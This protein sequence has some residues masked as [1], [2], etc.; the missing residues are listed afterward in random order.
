MRDP[1]GYSTWSSV[2]IDHEK[3]EQVVN[4]VVRDLNLELSRMNVSAHGVILYE[5]DGHPED[6]CRLFLSPQLYSSLKPFR[7]KWGFRNSAPPL[8]LNPVPLVETRELAAV[9]EY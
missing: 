8:G 2:H 5:V 9:A 3:K 4:R 7:V 6:G 1:Y